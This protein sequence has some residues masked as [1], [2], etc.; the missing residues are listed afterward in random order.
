MNA[1]ACLPRQ[2]VADGAYALSCVQAQHTEPIRL[3]RNAQMDVLRQAAPISAEQQQRY[4]A[5]HIWPTLA[6][7]QPANV[8]LALHHQGQLIGYGGLVHIAWEH[9][10]AEVSFLLDDARTH[11]AAGYAADFSA[12]LNLLATV[13]FD[14]L[15]F[16]RLFTETYAMRHH[17][18]QVLQANGFELEGVLRQHVL[19][20]G[21]PVDSLMHGR[22]SPHLSI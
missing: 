8:L 14:D 18:I 6:L 22:L 7:P 17:H 13:A 20:N 11:D 9:R 3:W 2:H 1:Y 5:Q 19:I 12:F 16:R 4:F 15:G 10:R 21:E